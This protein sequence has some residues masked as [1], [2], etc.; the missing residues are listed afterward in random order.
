MPSLSGIQGGGLLPGGSAQPLRPKSDPAGSTT[1]TPSSDLSPRPAAL[2]T[3]DTPR[4]RVPL[5]KTEAKQLQNFVENF[6]TQLFQ[7]NTEQMKESMDKLFNKDED[8][9]DEDVEPEE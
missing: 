6:A 8:E 4:V 5:P 9:D 1:P 2:Q 7:S 3:A